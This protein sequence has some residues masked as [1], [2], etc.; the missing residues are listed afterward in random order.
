M[1][2]L[3]FEIRFP[4]SFPNAPPFFRIIKPRFLPFIQGGGGHVTGGMHYASNY[5]P[6]LSLIIS[7][8][9]AVPF[10]WTC[11]L[12]M[13]SFPRHAIHSSDAYLSFSGWLPSYS[14]SA[15]LMQ[16]K[17]AI[18]NLDPRPARLAPRGDWKRY[19]SSFNLS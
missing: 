18:S 1:N 15:V 19:A 9:Q 5:G 2:S 16:I 7:R 12:P 10:A 17:L 11:S 14:I 4:P 8:L 13:V 3:I 6:Y